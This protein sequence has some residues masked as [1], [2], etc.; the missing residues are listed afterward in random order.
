MWKFQIIKETGFAF[1]VTVIRINTRLRRFGVWEWLVKRGFKK[2][3]REIRKKL[4]FNLVHLH[5]RDRV[6]HYVTELPEMRNIPFVLTEHFSFYHR[7]LW[8]KPPA[9]QRQ[10]I[11]QITR[12]FKNPQ[13]KK[14]MPVSQD[15]ANTMC[16]KFGL[17]PGKVKVIPN[18]AHPAFHY[19]PEAGIDPQRIVLFGNWNPP[20]NPVLFLDALRMPG[21]EFYKNLHIDWIGMGSQMDEIKAHAEQHLPGLQVAFRGF[22]AKDE[23]A[24]IVSR[25]AFMVHPTDAENLPT[26]IIECLCCGTPVLSMAV[27][28]I[29]ELVDNSNGLLVPARN[30]R[31]LTEALSWMV[32][33]H[34]GFD[35]RAI[36]MKAHSL[37]SPQAVALQ[38]LDVYKEIGAGG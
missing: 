3:L 4:D 25:S 19:R 7:G 12:L 24:E 31:A 29:P 35:R 6:S 34:Q 18:I 27:N 36:A 15:L 26:V 28:G 5:V 30:A 37:Y 20:K 1:P 38:I 14:V 32:Q 33:N 16:E 8:Q 13:L 21:V 23:I 10:Q 2:G 22:M 11:E 9:E 17:S